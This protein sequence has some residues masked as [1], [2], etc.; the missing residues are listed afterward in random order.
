MKLSNIQE[1]VANDVIQELV[2]SSAFTGIVG[3]I[4]PNA[5]SVNEG[6]NL[7][8]TVVTG[9]DAT[10]YYWIEGIT[11]TVDSSDFTSGWAD[12]AN[13]GTF[14]VAGGTGSF[15]LS[16][17]SD[18]STDGIETFRV[19]VS[20]NS[21]GAEFAQSA[22]VTINDTSVP[23]TQAQGSTS[24]YTSG[25]DTDDIFNYDKK[26]IDKFSFASNNNAVAVGDLSIGR[27]H[28]SGQSS[29]THGYSSGGYAPPLGTFWSN[30]IDKFPFTSDT[31]AVDVGDLAT[32]VQ[33]S[34]GNTST[35][36]GYV[37]GGR[38]SPSPGITTIQKFPFASDT[39]AS[40]IS[41]YLSVGRY[42]GCGQSSET[43]GYVTGGS[44]T[45]VIDKFPFASD[46]AGTATSAGNLSSRSSAFA[47][48]NSA[49]NGYA[50]VGILPQSVNIIDK[51]PFSS[52]VG[53]NDIGDLTA[54][55]GSAA[56]QSSTENGYTSGGFFP[57]YNS[58]NVIDKFPFASDESATDV[59]DLTEG[60]YRA[61]GQQY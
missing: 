29:T 13:R 48:Q 49:A 46:V 4:G 17:A 39:N 24:G 57:P 21:S 47:G 28:V 5:L 31:N 34:Q 44:P 7:N 19:K 26:T 30:I 16:L 1:D 40:N 60:R 12:S 55:R 53:A 20:K 14:S 56:G 10:Y 52:D 54:I 25:G 45:L 11:G 41:N 36:H 27:D 18:Q 2:D 33:G 59:G 15:T 38:S 22:I 61:A 9:N 8:F 37:A 32:A 23:P 35:T 3:R 58:S 51:F 43:H 42:R 6:A 50:S